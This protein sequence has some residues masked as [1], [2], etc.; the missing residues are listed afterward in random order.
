MLLFFSQ[1]LFLLFRS[2]QIQCTTHNMRANH[3][4]SIHKPMLTIFYVVLLSFLQTTREKQITP[5]HKHTE[6]ETHTRK[7][8]TSPDSQFAPLTRQN[9]VPKN[10]ITNMNFKTYRVT[11]CRSQNASELCSI[12]YRIE[13]TMLCSVCARLARNRELLLGFG[14]GSL[15][16]WA[17]HGHSQHSE[18]KRRLGVC[19]YVC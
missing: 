18:C 2:T 4:I 6:K 16:Y 10:K 1:F 12:S 15:L 9:Y 8:R 13:P 5:I 3:R 14:I 7:N 17:G 11:L 19:M